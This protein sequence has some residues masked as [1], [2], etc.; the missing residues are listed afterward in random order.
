MRLHNKNTFHLLLL[1]SYDT[2]SKYK[3]KNVLT[4][5]SEVSYVNACSTK[6]FLFFYRTQ[7]L[8]SY[9]RVSY[10]KKNVYMGKCNQRKPGKNLFSVVYFF[11]ELTA[12][13]LFLTYD[14]LQ[15]TVTTFYWTKRDIL[16]VSYRV[17]L[18]IK[19]KFSQR[20]FG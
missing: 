1:S 11:T 5:K 4:K 8:V 12:K 13:P 3:Q 15:N 6:S 16:I 17:C 14:N 2:H 9:K 10:N 19:D 7:Y 18:L 20:E